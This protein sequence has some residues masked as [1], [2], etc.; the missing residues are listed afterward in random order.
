MY[1]DNLAPA[2]AATVAVA[3]AS[4]SWAL[5][6]AALAT[7]LFVLVVRFGPRVLALRGSR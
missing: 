5:T 7:L 6:A 2:G 1:N 3:G 4:L